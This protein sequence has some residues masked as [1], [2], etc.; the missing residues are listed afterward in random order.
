[1][2]QFLLIF[3]I[4]FVSCNP[5][6][7]SSSLTVMTYNLR[8]DVAS[9]GDNAWPNRS[10]FLISQLRFFEPNVF[11]TQEGRPHQIKELKQKLTNYNF[12]GTGREGKNKGEYSA[13]FYDT[14]QVAFTNAKTFWLSNTPNKFSKVGM[15]HIQEFAPMV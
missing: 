6:D 10:D 15:L 3:I 11:G 14:T 13:I 5:K 1:M 12:I 9:D 7:S 2:K 4:V 8:L